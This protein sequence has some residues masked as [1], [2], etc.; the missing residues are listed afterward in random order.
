MNDGTVFIVDD[1]QGLL[2]SLELLLGSVG[3]DVRSFK[4]PNDFLNSYQRCAGCVLID[5]RMPEMTGLA[6]QTELVKRGI[7]LSV[8]LMTGFADANRTARAFKEGA[9]DF[10]EKPFQPEELI[11]VVKGALE[12]GCEVFREDEESHEFHA[13]LASLTPRERDVFD[14]LLTGKPNKLMAD[15]LEI[16]DRTIEVHRARVMKKMGGDS[17]AELVRLATRFIAS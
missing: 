12:R 8:V 5:D 1:D 3:L 6:L 15:A 4:S 17:V 7:P 2:G 14:Q 13:K 9:V 16:S 10:I 11:D